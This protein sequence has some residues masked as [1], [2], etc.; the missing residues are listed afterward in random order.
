MYVYYTE[1]TGRFVMMITQLS[2]L[3]VSDDADNTLFPTFIKLSDTES[4]RIDYYCMSYIY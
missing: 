3:R 4:T 1:E 2:S